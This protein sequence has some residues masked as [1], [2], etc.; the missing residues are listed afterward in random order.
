MDKQQSAGSSGHRYGALLTIF[1]GSV[2]LQPL[3]SCSR[4]EALQDSLMLANT[5]RDVMPRLQFTADLFAP[6]EHGGDE[7]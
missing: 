6:A 2:Q 7:G 3:G 1:P 5:G 4:V